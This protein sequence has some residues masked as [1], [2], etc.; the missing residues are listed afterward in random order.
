MK[1]RNKLSI[2]SGWVGVVLS[3][4][5]GWAQGATP[6][7]STASTT[8]APGE[9]S[10]GGSGTLKVK[11]APGQPQTFS[12]DT[13]GGNGHVCDFEGELKGHEGRVKNE[14]DPSQDCILKL[15]TTGANVEVTAVNQEV[16]RNHCGA[17][18]QFEGSYTLLTPECRPGAVTATRAKFKKS[19]TAKDYAGARDLLAG[20]LKS[21]APVIN[22]LDVMWIRNDLALTQHHAGDDAGCLATLQPL[23]DLAKQDP[24]EVG[25]TE[26]AYQ[27]DLKKVAKATRTNLALCTGTKAKK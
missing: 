20:V 9:Y 3:L 4:M 1:W 8:V 6:A 22:W 24:D 21:C 19:Y 25:S 7:G 13:V 23:E 2:R 14:D 10:Y 5:S 27:D 26:P 15:E 16:C 17:R 18:G 12:I 11:G